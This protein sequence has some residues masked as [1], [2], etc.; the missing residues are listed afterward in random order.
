MENLLLIYLIKYQILMLKNLFK[1]EKVK[2][3]NKICID[4]INTENTTIIPKHL[5]NTEAGWEWINSEHGLKWL[6][7]DDGLNWMLS[8]Y[9]QIWLCSNDGLEWLKSNDGINWLSSKNSKKWLLKPYYG[10]NWLKS[11][12]KNSWFNHSKGKNWLKLDIGIEWLNT[13]DGYEWLN[14]EESKDWLSS[15]EYGW[16]WLL[17]NI[18]SKRWL[19]SDGGIDWLDSYDG[20]LWLKSVNSEEWLSSKD[21]GWIFLKY[22]EGK[23]WLNTQDGYKWLSSDNGNIW[24]STSDDAVKWIVTNGDK[25]VDTPGGIAW[26]KTPQGINF[27]NSNDCLYFLENKYG[28]GFTDPSHKP[29]FLDSHLG[30]VYLNLSNI[31]I[32]YFLTTIGNQYLFNTNYRIIMRGN[33]QEWFFSEKGNKFMSSEVGYQFMDWYNKFKMG[34][35]FIRWIDS[36]DGELWITNNMDDVLSQ[37]HKSIEDAKN[38]KKGV[39]HSNIDDDELMKF[40][41]EMD[42][43]THVGINFDEES[44]DDG[45]NIL[46]SDDI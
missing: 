33:M 38:M 30:D 22:N 43:N 20:K 6:N 36:D 35:E 2:K 4:E 16:H 24:L 15:Y 29:N 14:S 27:L 23:R 25:W 10:L 34:I 26:I 40:I 9:G 17:N 41:A 11:E 32:N 12:N 45:F 46:D 8:D 7:S 5:I 21:Y 1:K 42:D 19:I 39:M 31:G 18:Y 13:E 28:E 3:G 37:I 44:S